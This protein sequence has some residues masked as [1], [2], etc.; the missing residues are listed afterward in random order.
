[1]STPKTLSYIIS[2]NGT[3][4][5][6]VG[7]KAYVL[8]SSSI[9]YSAAKKALK[10]K[11][12]DAFVAQCNLE[13]ALRER[14]NGKVTLEAGVIRWNGKPVNNALTKRIY[15]L[16][17]EDFPFEPLLAFLENTLKNPEQRAVDELYLFLEKNALPI[18]EDGHFLAYRRVGP[19]FLSIHKNPDGTRN[20]NKPGD[21]VTMPR[22]KCDAD[23]TETCSKGLHFCS[24]EYLPSYSGEKTVIVKINPADVVAIPI[25]YNNQKGRCCRYEVVGEYVENDDKDVL[26][27]AAVY[28]V[29]PTEQSPLGV[30]PSGQRYHSKRDPQTG[31]WSKSS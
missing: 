24:I 19:D 16:I 18:T 11:N 17:R 26:T 7:G 30:K 23:R 28:Q 22:D 10:D 6:V 1:M 4:N 9:F 15:N 12:A 8:P 29:T 5:A 21:V 27:D 13:K 25:D 20:R 2:D 3:I 31:R 14:S